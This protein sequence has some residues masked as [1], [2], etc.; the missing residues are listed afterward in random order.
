VVH[1]S[2]NA[3]GKRDLSVVI[4]ATA[5]HPADRKQ[6]YGLPTAWISWPHWRADQAG[7]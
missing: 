3:A 4:D 1:T 2:A 6:D 7:V 5:P